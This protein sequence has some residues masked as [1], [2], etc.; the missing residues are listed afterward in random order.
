MQFKKTVLLSFGEEKLDEVE[1]DAEGEMVYFSRESEDIDI[2]FTFE[3][4]DAIIAEYQ[5]E[6]QHTL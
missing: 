1:I 6:K 2:S 4:F 5:N 3:E